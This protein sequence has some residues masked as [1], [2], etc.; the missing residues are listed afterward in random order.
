MLVTGFSSL[1][2]ASTSLLNNFFEEMGIQQ[3]KKNTSPE[4]GASQ[5]HTAWVDLGTQATEHV[6]TAAGI[7]NNEGPVQQP[8]THVGYQCRKRDTCQE[9]PNRQMLEEGSGWKKEWNLMA[10]GN[11]QRVRI[12]EGYNPSRETTVHQS[13]GNHGKGFLF[14]MTHPAISKKRHLGI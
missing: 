10:G 6:L 4:L 5:A 7:A 9:L 1:A 12:S 11:M 8:C 2:P 14:D 3:Q 13:R